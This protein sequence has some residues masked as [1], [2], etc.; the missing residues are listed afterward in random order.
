M[1]KPG[2]VLLLLVVLGFLVT[3]CAGYGAMMA[4]SQTSMAMSTASQAL[5]LGTSVAS[6]VEQTDVR[7]SL[8]P[9]VTSEELR[10]IK[11]LGL[12]FE[13]RGFP[14]GDPAGVVADNVALE[15]LAL[16]Y[17]VQVVR[18]DHALKLVEAQGTRSGLVTPETVARIGRAHGLDA[19]VLGSVTVAS[20]I[21][22]SFTVSRTGMGQVIQ[23]V[24]LRVV[25][26]ERGEVVLAAALS[27][28]KGQTPAEA[29]KVIAHVLREKLQ[30][31]PAGKS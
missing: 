27:Y 16:G 24:S 14:G 29:A 26:V 15:F 18:E 11:K 22:G 10:R 2:E 28:K 12:V 23:N 4:L 20:E 3:G 30:G 6:L 1:R 9:G 31:P 5:H 17:Q 13:G 25:S 8:A 19:V 21:A 7:A